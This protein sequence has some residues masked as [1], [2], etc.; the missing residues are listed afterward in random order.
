M[1]IAIV[2]AGITELSAAFALSPQHDVTPYNDEIRPDGHGHTL[3]LNMPE[4]P[5]SVDDGG[6]ELKGGAG[7]FALFVQSRNPVL[8]R[9]MSLL[10]SI[11]R[12][13]KV[14]RRAL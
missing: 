5:V 8:P 12:F 11:V 2:G 6:L 9:F 10:Q 7:P 3:T 13:H 1:K 4:N 14:A